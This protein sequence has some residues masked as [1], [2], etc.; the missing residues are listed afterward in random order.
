MDRTSE[1]NSFTACEGSLHSPKPYEDKFFDVMISGLGHLSEKLDG[2]KS[3]NQILEIEREFNTLVKES[4]SLLN[5]IELEG[6]G[7]EI[8]HFEGIKEIIRLKV[9][10][11]ALKVQKKKQH[12]ISYS[13]DLEPEKPVLFVQKNK[14]VFEEENQRL[15]ERFQSKT[16][17]LTR[18]KKQL[19]EIEGIQDLIKI[20]LCEQDER[21]NSIVL[22]AKMAKKT[23]NHSNTY[24]SKGRNSGRLFRRI[25]FIF[26]LC[27]SFV[28]MFSHIFHR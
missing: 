25:L 17:E 26:T 6:S 3:Y 20:H 23:L 11:L 14:P 5:V 18:T 27:A 15:V 7:D 4:T 10:D 16:S 12:M 24:F 28:L 21:I 8:M 2:R 9:A 13:T 22:S 1:Y 19:I